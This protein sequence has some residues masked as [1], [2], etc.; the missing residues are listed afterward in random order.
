[1]MVL[2]GTNTYTGGTTVAAG[3][4][5]VSADANLGG[6]SGGVALGGGTLEL[7]GSFTLGAGRTI[8][9]ATGTSSTIAVTSGTVSFA[10]A[11][12]GSGNLDKAGAGR[13]SV[14]NAN[15]GYTGTFTISAGTLEVTAASVFANATLTQT[16]GTLLLAPQGG[17]DVAI[18]EI[19]GSGGSVTID[20]GANAVFGGASSRSYGG[21]ING[22]GGLKKQGAGTLTLNGNNPFAGPTR[23]EAG[24]LRLGA[25][26][27]L[28]GTPS[29]GVES[30]AFFDVSARAGFAL[31]PGQRLG[32]R[33]TV[34]GDLQFAS[35]S[36]LAFDPTGPT[37]IGSGTVSFAAGFGIGSI[38]GLNSG[39]AQGTYTLLDETAGGVID[40]TNLANV[41][42]ANAFDLGGGTSAYFQQGSLQVVVVPEPSAYFLCGLGLA[43][44]GVVTAA[45]RKR[46]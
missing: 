43:A 40:L 37:L 14:S 11:F 33:G 29:I 5:S 1:M 13:L 16:G 17:G 7:T 9:A 38:F 28:P 30:G 32:G 24:S 25:G 22:Q 4:L 31:G 20:A 23:V 36:Q 44:A 27:S 34:I 42:A 45:G 19:G 35:G 8:T 3:T 21:Q 2:T 39:V 10:G 41:G 18:P 6:A 46:R 26:G 15:S 12:A